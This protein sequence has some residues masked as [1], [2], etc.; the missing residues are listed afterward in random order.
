MRRAKTFRLILVLIEGCVEGGVRLF[1]LKRASTANENPTNA[2]EYLAEHFF[3]IGALTFTLTPSY[4]HL[5]FEVEDAAPFQL[6]AVIDEPADHLSA[7]LRCLEGAK[8]GLAQPVR[9]I[10][11]KHT[12]GGACDWV[13]RNALDGSKVAAD[14]IVD[15]VATRGHDNSGPVHASNRPHVGS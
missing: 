13:L 12:V 3:L 10:W 9:P 2:N 7:A 8:L 4:F 15:A 14:E 11:S 6:S 1:R 5:A